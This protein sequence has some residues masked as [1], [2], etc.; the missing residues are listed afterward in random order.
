MEGHRQVQGKKQAMET[1][2]PREELQS[3]PIAPLQYLTLFSDA[4][5]QRKK[6]SDSAVKQLVFT[7]DEYMKELKKRKDVIESNLR[8]FSRFEDQLNFRRPR[9][10]KDLMR[11]EKMTEKSS[12]KAPFTAKTAESAQNDAD[13]ETRSTTSD[14]HPEKSQR[15]SSPPPWDMS[16]RSR[17][18]PSQKHFAARTVSQT[19]VASMKPSTLFTEFWKGIDSIY[20]PFSREHI[21]LML[22]REKESDESDDCESPPAN[23]LS[24]MECLLSCLL[25]PEGDYEEMIKPSKRLRRIESD[26]SV[27][28]K[29]IQHDL[30]I[31]DECVEEELQSLGMVEPCSKLS[32]CRPN[33][34]ID[35][36]LLVLNQSLKECQS[37][38]RVLCNSF[39]SRFLVELETDKEMRRDEEELRYA[40]NNLYIAH[41][42]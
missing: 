40:Q 15:S 28:S 23:P 4:S 41:H 36:E 5:F 3:L 7:L 9:E 1:P 12:Q 33:G 21:Q 25:V 38:L 32:A 27:I 8:V 18:H 16:L 24:S 6:I 35:H 13:Y 20:K 39:C 17:M 10:T 14:T 11:L 34:S 19:K 31:L 22:G 29:A 30:V 2:F 42:S 26:E 37:E